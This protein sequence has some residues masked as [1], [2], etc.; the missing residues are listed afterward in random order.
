MISNE[1]FGVPSLV[2]ASSQAACG[3]DLVESLRRHVGPEQVRTNQSTADLCTYHVGGPARLAVFPKTVE[4]L[5]AV[6]RFLV[7][8]GVHFDVLGLGSNVLVADAGLSDP[9]VV[10][11]EMDRVVVDGRRI[12]AQA[13]VTCS[14]VAR[15]ALDHG[16]TGLEFFHGL[17]GSVGGA[18]FMNARAFGQEFRDWAVGAKVVTRR[19]DVLAMR[20]SPDLFAY[21]RSPFMDRELIVEEVEWLLEKAPRDQI[22]AQMDANGHH[23]SQNGERE[24]ASCGCVFKNP[25]GRSA[26]KLVDACG[27][28][29]LRIGGAWV[30][31]RHG[32]FVVHDGQACAGDIRAVMEKV[33][34]D[35]AAKT[36]VALDYEVRFLGKWPNQDD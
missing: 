18:A 7:E 29:G 16:L 2:A 14:E 22:R 35:V 36:G 11:A 17:P 3:A 25:A 28:K 21:K 6:I 32:N 33:R 31:E 5:S 26:G 12:R 23:R 8:Q 30:S 24:F 10:T 1:T 27:L 4:H 13:G 34:R 19:G 20:L 15:V 9:V